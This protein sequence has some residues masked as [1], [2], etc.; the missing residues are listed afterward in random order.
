ML[1]FLAKKIMISILI[2]FLATWMVSML[3]HSVSI[4]PKQGSPVSYLEWI[5]NL[6]TFRFATRE[7]F[8]KTFTT[9]VLTFGSLAVSLLFSIPLGISSALRNDS[10]WLKFISKFI[11]SICFT[12]AFVTAYLFILLD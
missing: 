3:M 12:P 10:I 8:A 9:L 6:V 2:L 4:K 11:D 7:L 5:E 1:S